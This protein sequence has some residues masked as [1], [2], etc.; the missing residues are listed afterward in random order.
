MK[1]LGN[2]VRMA[3]VVGW[4]EEGRGLRGFV[5]IRSPRGKLGG[6]VI[7]RAG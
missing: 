1:S 4:E 5:Y 2:W 7:S 6:S 3:V